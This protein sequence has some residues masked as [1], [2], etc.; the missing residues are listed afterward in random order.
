M[1]QKMAQKIL[2]CT[3]THVMCPNE[4]TKKESHHLSVSTIAIPG[5]LITQA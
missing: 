5:T 4:L 3:E 2:S 1:G